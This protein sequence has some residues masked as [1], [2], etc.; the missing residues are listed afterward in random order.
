[1]RCYIMGENGLSIADAL[2]LARDNDGNFGGNGL[3]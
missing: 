3:W 1:M 2:A